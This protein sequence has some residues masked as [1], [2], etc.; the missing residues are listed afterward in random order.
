M[1]LLTTQ[2]K[3]KISFVLHC[4]DRIIIS[5]VMPEISYSQGMTAY[6]YKSQ[7]KVFDYPKFA[8]PYRD[9]IRQNAERL[10]RENGIDI[11]F[12]SN[13]NLSKEKIVSKVIEKRG[14]S[15]GLVHILSAM[16]LCPT[17]KPW[18]DIKSGKAFVK[19]AHSKCLHY[20][21]YFIDEELGLSYVRVPTWA[22]FRLQIYINGHNM[23][24][25]AL[26]ASDNSYTMVD[27][28]FEHISNVENAQ[29]LADNVDIKKIHSRLDNIAWR[30]CPVYK[31][32][33][34]RYHWSIIQA[35]YATDIV[36]KNQRDLQGI[37]NE[38][39]VSAIH[40]VKP[41][42]IA[43]FLGRKLYN[44]YQGEMGNNYNVRIEGTR[45]KHTMGKTSIKMYDKF[46]KILRIETTTNEVNFFKHYREV[47]HR[48]GTK[49]MQMASLK[50]VIY[51]LNLL[52]DNLLAANRRY[53]E[54][55]SAF[56]N[57]EIGRKKLEKIT[58][59]KA[60]NNR[61]YKGFNFF[62]KKDLEILMTII[63]GEFN[64]RGFQNKDLRKLLK[65]TS[66]QASRLIKRLR[67]HGLIKKAANTYKYYLQKL[68]KEC[69]VVASKIKEQILIPSF[70]H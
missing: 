4:Y 64:I 8:E 20:Y 7:I 53:L 70:C 14:N 31:N 6:L 37:Y 52:K 25:R 26:N 35:E 44:Q 54:F 24:A 21:F 69:I 47:V 5:G 60:Q 34:F 67:V 11:E 42:N 40:T 3:D 17:F 22:P 58:R 43:T 55:I 23:L 57:K 2:Y 10:A 63:R 62:D 18:Y 68:G 12:I 39:V 29:Q 13:A 33:G 32:L 50:R 46:G 19:S 28:A 16:E 1:E 27:N 51:S 66:G 9:Q 61:M 59:S 41:D 49:S 56:D 48:D 38:L 65:L 30:Y 15:P 45:I 36:F